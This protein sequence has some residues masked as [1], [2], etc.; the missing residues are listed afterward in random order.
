[1]RL[2]P[3]R[4][5]RALLAFLLVAP[6]PSAQAAGAP[7]PPPEAV[8]GVLPFQAGEEANRVLVDLAQE[9]SEPFVMLLDTGASASV[10]SPLMARKLGVMVRRNKQSPYRRATR[11]GRD[12][13]FWI[14]TRS[15]DSGSKTGYE[16][17]LLGGD[18]LSEYVVEIDFP[19]RR[20]RLLD[21]KR[22][23]VPEQS[24]AA[25][26][27]VVSFDLVGQRILV[28][29]ELNG[30]SVDVL[31]DTGA[32]DNLILSGQA[33]RRVGIDVDAL[34]DFGKGSLLLGPM[35]LRF[36]EAPTLR[37]ASFDFDPVP[38]LVA[39][40]GLY[41][42]AP[43]DSLI[44]Y[45]LLSQFVVRIDY[46]RHRLW[47]KRSGDRRVTYLGVDYAATKKLGVYLVPHAGALWVSRVSEGGPAAAFGLRVG[48]AIVPP[49]GERPLP[50]GEVLRRIEARE[51]LTV[52][53]QQGDVWVDH[54]LPEAKDP[55][56]P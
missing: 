27:Q 8:V 37:L 24:D 43:N 11:L 56:A 55:A 41:N 19:A 26:E 53:R 15:T 48:D 23:R 29:V 9:G 22:Y 47:L 21:S 44:G 18:F 52:A 33:A 14:D 17:G 32:P 12:V 49:A 38:V 35:S 46:P 4:L 30:K 34:P 40:R 42:L 54:A 36:Y 1:M 3:R 50:S 13:Q 5:G 28:P 39:P 25:D 45:D 2:A 7:E 20:V 16:Y 51:D 31:L 10:V 6:A